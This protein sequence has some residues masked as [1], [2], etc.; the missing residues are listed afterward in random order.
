M[1]LSQILSDV[2]ILE[3]SFI[4]L[5]VHTF[6]VHLILLSWILSLTL[7]PP[8]ISFFAA[9]GG[10]VIF[11]VESSKIAWIAADRITALSG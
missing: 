4:I 7:I 8:C 3:P 11:G 9:I 2:Y 1:V 10:N 6:I 5:V